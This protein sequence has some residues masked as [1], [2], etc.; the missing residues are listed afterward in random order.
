MTVLVMK[1]RF[2]LWWCNVVVIWSKEECCHRVGGGG[3]YCFECGRVA[4]GVGGVLKESEVVE[5]SVFKGFSTHSLE[6]AKLSPFRCGRRHFEE[7]LVETCTVSVTST[8]VI[9]SSGKMVK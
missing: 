4:S 6:A 1:M 2:P 8:V 9:E 5:V 7:I 3:R